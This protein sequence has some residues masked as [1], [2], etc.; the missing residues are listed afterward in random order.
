MSAPSFTLE[1]RVALV[2]GAGSGIGAGVARA[3][4]ACGA[5][6]GCLDLSTDGVERTVAAISD[7]GGTA[8]ALQ[9]DVV[10]EAST[11]AAV[12]ALEEA[13]GALSAA[14]NCAGVH[15]TA[16]AESMSRAQW[17]RVIDVNLTGVFTSCQVEGRAMMAGGGGAIV[18]VSSISARIANQGLDQVHYNASK[19]AVSHLT[20]S[21]ALEW[22]EHGIRVNALSPG[23]TA[24]PMSRAAEGQTVVTN[25]LDHIPMRRMARV[26]DLV[27]PVVFLLSD[28]SAYCTGADLVVDGGATLW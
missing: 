8:V 14:V 26:A 10:D 16:P 21:L 9:A 23:Y 3:L 20:R 25:Y 11:A 13:F 27:G 15:D 28:A 22:V 4:A 5:A 1:S 17:Q 12:A 7:E 18:N 24:T 19:A 6:V 2:T